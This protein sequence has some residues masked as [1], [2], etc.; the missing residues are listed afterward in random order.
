TSDDDQITVFRR[1]S[2]P[3]ML[4]ININGEISS[5]QDTI[6]LIQISGSDGN[7]TI[8]IDES[9]GAIALP[10][11]IYGGAGDD[12]LIGG[13]GQDRIKGG[14]GNDWISGGAGNDVI[15]GQAGNDRLFGG[16]GKDYLNGGLISADQEINVLRGGDGVD[17][18]AIGS[19]DDVR[20]NR[21]D[22]V[23]EING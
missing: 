15:Y 7:D 13:S 19:T 9:N 17:T 8:K 18:L 2:R 10:T 14:D 12:V 21:G 16:A 23:I 22:I 6:S 1:S 5:F 4:D 20:G 11:K 3:Y